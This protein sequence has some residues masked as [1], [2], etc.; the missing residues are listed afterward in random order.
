[1]SGHHVPMFAVAD[2]PA[3]VA[4]ANLGALERRPGGMQAPGTERDT[5]MIEKLQVPV[6]LDWLLTCTVYIGWLHALEQCC[7]IP[8]S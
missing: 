8:V 4:A 6:G 2:G 5:A 1:M 3:G 7:V